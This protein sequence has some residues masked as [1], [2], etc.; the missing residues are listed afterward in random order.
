[1][2][3]LVYILLLYRVLYVLIVK[4]YDGKA[5]DAIT[6]VNAHIKLYHLH[7]KLYQLYI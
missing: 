3:A 5:N 1:M 4:F 2:N 6:I 7:I